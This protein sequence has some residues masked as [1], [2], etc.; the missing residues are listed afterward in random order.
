MSSGRLEAFTDGVVAIIITIMV[1]ELKVPRDGSL[2][3]LSDSLPILLAYILSFINVGLYWNNH[4]HLLHATDRIDGKVLWANLFLLF[5]LSL[6][7]FVIRWLDASGFSAMATASYGVVLAMAAIGYELT[8]RAIIA[9][10]GTQSA[11]ARA[12]G[13][14]R[15]GK[16]TLALYAVAVPAAFFARPVAI[17]LYIIVLLPWL[18]PDR[19]IERA[20]GD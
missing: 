4:H 19:R 7:P 18:A 14:D 9:C 13:S 17:A 6:V 10:N 8:E 3:A 20:L 1:L 12:V 2:A 15:K 5:W 11:L 16:I